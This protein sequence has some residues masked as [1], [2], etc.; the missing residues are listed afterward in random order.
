MEKK[1]K[2]KT[3]DQ[4]A[5]V[6]RFMNDSY[7]SGAKFTTFTTFL[8]KNPVNFLLALSSGILSLACPLIWKDA[9]YN[10]EQFPNFTS[11]QE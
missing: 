4:A 11:H 10:F 5:R 8:K 2:R 7:L 6:A 3:K 9:A 1:K